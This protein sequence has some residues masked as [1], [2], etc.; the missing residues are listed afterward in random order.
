MTTSAKRAASRAIRRRATQRGA[1]SIPRRRAHGLDYRRLR[2]LPRTRDGP[3]T[4][5][6][7]CRHDLPGVQRRRPSRRCDRRRTAWP[8]TCSAPT[9]L[10][11]LPA[12][13]FTAGSAGAALGRTSVAPSRPPRPTG[14]RIRRTRPRRRRCGPR[15]RDRERVPVIAV[16]AGLQRRH[17]DQLRRDVPSRVAD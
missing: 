1:T 17:P 11:G 14:R 3:C 8:R 15:R 6:P 5:D 2:R 13:L 4:T 10:S 9:S 12:T 7:H 16:A